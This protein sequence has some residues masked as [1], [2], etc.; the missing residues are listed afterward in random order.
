MGASF[1]DVIK[2]VIIYNKRVKSL[3]WSVLVSL[4]CWV[5]PLDRRYP[6]FQIVWKKKFS[7]KEKK[8]HKTRICSSRKQLLLC[9]FQSEI[10]SSLLIPSAYCSYQRAK[11]EEEITSVKRTPAPLY[12]FSTLPWEPIIC[13]PLNK[14]APYHITN[15]YLTLFSWAFTRQAKRLGRG[16]RRGRGEGR[17]VALSLDFSGRKDKFPVYDTQSVKC[18][19]ALLQPPW[20]AAAWI[21]EFHIAQRNFPVPAL[22][23]PSPSTLTPPSWK[24]SSIPSEDPSKFNFLEAGGLGVERESVYISSFNKRIWWT[25]FLIPSCHGFVFFFRDILWL[26]HHQKME[27]AKYVHFLSSHNIHFLVFLFQCCSHTMGP[28]FVQD[29]KKKYKQRMDLE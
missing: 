10:K 7:S 24:L 2:Q 14:Q 17:W 6:H 26:W 11:P 5:F 3:I 28:I 8:I 29:K 9:L 12:Y 18:Q 1:R 27:S 23:H 16:L 21:P 22:F 4:P 19:A 13:H 15:I 25:E 20:K